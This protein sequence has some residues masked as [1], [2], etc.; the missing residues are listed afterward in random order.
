MALIAGRPLAVTLGGQNL[1][2]SSGDSF[3]AESS[4]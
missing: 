2:I 3:T 1:T 4:I